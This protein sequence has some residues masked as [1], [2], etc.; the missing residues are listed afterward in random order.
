[1]R[2]GIRYQEEKEVAFKVTVKKCFKC[3]KL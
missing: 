2:I 1:M 3:N